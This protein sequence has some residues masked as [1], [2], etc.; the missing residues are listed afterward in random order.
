MSSLNSESL[1][2]SVSWSTCWDGRVKPQGLCDETLKT[3][4]M[5]KR[6][7]V[8]DC[9]VRD[10]FANEVLVLGVASEVV[11]DECESDTDCVTGES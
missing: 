5:L 3:G 1:G 2:T 7:D 9:R 11:E 10:L 8:C 6:L 4:K